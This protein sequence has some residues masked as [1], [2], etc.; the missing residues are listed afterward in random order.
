MGILKKFVENSTFGNCIF[1]HDFSRPFI[2]VPGNLES[3]SC[4]GEFNSFLAPSARNSWN[5]FQYMSKQHV[6]GYLYPQA[7]YS[8]ILKSYALKCSGVWNN[9]MKIRVSNWV[10]VSII[11]ERGFWGDTMKLYLMQSIIWFQ[12]RIYFPIGRFRLPSVV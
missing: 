9:E 11:E 10:T 7:V 3:I 8:P 4:G 2:F 12:R 6:H 1:F 5:A